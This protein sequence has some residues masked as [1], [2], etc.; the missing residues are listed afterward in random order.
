MEARRL[1]QQL[2][3]AVEYCHS[4][5]VVNRDI[6]PENVL[7]DKDRRLLKLTDFGYAK[8]NQD[9]L[10]KSKV[11]TPNYAGGCPPCACPADL[12]AP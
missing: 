8:S 3:I 10:P 7:L 12:S 4:T 6:K 2:V 9:S 11:G 5:G 1:F